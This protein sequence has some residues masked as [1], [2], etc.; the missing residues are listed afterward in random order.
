MHAIAAATAATPDHQFTIVSD[1]LRR[2]TVSS[3]EDGLFL[4]VREIL[5]P[6]ARNSQWRF[7]RPHLTDPDALIYT[8]D[9]AAYKGIMRKHE[10]VKHSVGEYVRD[11]VSTNGIE[12]F[13]SMLKR[14]YVGTYHHMSPKHLQRYVDETADRHNVRPMDTVNQMALAV[15]ES[16]GRRLSYKQLIGKADKVGGPS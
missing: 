8:D 10:S 3:F 1:A 12:S 7:R 15:Q 11:Q 5:Q 4:H 9:A 13:L 6:L 2:F 14:G 16:E